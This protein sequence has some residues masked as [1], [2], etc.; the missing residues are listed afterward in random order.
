MTTDGYASGMA[1]HV[2]QALAQVRAIHRHMLEKQRFKGYSGRARA[3][4]GCVAL[5]GALWLAE[6]PALSPRSRLV[7]WVV[8][9]WISITINYGAVLAWYVSDPAGER[10]ASRLKPLA[11][12][13]PALLAGG[14]LTWVFARD[15]Q[16]QY[17]PGAWML[18]FGVAN[19]ASRHTVP[20][21]IVWI[22][23]FY[24]VAG[25]GALL[26]PRWEGLANPWPMGMVFF[27]GE[28]AAGLIM[29]REAAPRGS[30]TTFFGLPA[31]AANGSPDA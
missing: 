28:W 30:W 26:V 13:F 11:E 6:H 20:R 16:Q 9:A 22:G 12:I 25:A 2:H 4:S 23:A 15:G 19:C 7:T 27:A 24:L 18:L 17:F 8:V 3:A 1:S 31:R 21:P 29:H 10:R 5:L 14:L